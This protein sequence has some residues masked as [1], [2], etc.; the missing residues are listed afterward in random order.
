MNEIIEKRMERLSELTNKIKHLDE[1]ELSHLYELVSTFNEILFIVGDL[2]AEAKFVRD[3]A[4]RERKRIDAETK[5][6]TKG[7]GVV[8]E[9][10]AEIA[11]Q[12]YRKQENEADRM[13]TKY[14]NRYKA[15]DH[16]L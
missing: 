6:Q 16:R 5:L 7:T 15:F 1:N 14:R 10:T 8:K 4:Y 2:E 12:E 9:S 13:Y 3:E 11:I